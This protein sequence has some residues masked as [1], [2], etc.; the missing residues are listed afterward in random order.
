MNR[1]QDQ[2]LLALITGGAARGQ[3]G[4][5]RTLISF[6]AQNL[7]HFFQRWGAAA[8]GRPYVCWPPAVRVCVCV[9]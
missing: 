6:T 9:V 7:Q 1:S 8:L 4:G 5:L 2:T 3:E